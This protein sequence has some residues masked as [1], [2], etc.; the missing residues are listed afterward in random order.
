MI[1]AD[2]EEIFFKL[3][4]TFSKKKI[5]SRLLSFFFVDHIVD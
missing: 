5:H 1:E 3:R 4:R 2:D